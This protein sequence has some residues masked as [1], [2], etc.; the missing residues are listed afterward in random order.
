MQ[1]RISGVDP[2]GA[3]PHPFPIME[4]PIPTQNRTSEAGMLRL[5]KSRVFFFC[6]QK[7]VKNGGREGGREGGSAARDF[8]GGPRG[9]RAPPLP[10]NGIPCPDPK[11]CTTSARKSAS[12]SPPT[13]ETNHL[14]AFATSE[15]LQP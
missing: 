14:P 6:A 13:V 9:R 10:H 7:K 1:H 3:G 2:G 5:V 4:S 15:A 11:S 12:L 8:G